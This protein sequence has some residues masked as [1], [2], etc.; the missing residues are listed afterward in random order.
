MRSS[1]LLL[2]FALASA[3]P[4]AAFGLPAAPTGVVTDGTSADGW[5]ADAEASLHLGAAPEPA[6][7]EN[8]SE[9]R[10]RRLVRVMDAHWRELDAACDPAAVFALTYLYTTIVIGEHVVA[11][12]FDDGDHTATIQVAFAALYF[13]SYEA[14]ASGRP[15]DASK[16]WREA[17][18]AG[19]SGTT[20]VQEDVFLGMN[21]HINY[22]LAVVM[23]A[24]GLYDDEGRSRKPDHDRINDVLAKIVEPLSHMLADHYDESLR[25][26]PRSALTDPTVLATI[27]SW[28]ENAWRQAEAI[29]LLPTAAGRALHDQALQ[30]SAYTIAQ[31]FQTPKPEPTAPAR[32]AYCAAN[33]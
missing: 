29:A 20:T 12:Y 30:E 16:P 4:A 22:N 24:L 2:V 8:A 28:R 18:E 17:F 25:P 11:G 27:Y 13:E 9:R 31:A 5:L 10:I 33:P 3:A 6:A 15:E 14:F 32:V 21:A 7:V 23:E 26:G 1:P 19:A